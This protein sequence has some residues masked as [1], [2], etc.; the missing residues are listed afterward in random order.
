MQVHSRLTLVTA[1]IIFGTVGCASDTP[2]ETRGAK[3]EKL[4][5][6]VDKVVARF[7]PTTTEAHIN[8]WWR[9]DST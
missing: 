1:V 4:R 7:S 8:R 3:Q 5:I 2:S 9:R 6:L